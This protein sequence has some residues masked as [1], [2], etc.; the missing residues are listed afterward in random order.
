M[1]SS[2]VRRLPLMCTTEQPESE[3]AIPVVAAEAES[4]AKTR[5][6]RFSRVPSGG[7][8]ALGSR[9]FSNR[10]N[11]VRTGRKRK[12]W[13]KLSSIFADSRLHATSFAS[14]RYTSPDM[15]EHAE[16]KKKSRG[17]R[18]RKDRAKAADKETAVRKKEETE[19]PLRGD[20]I[21]MRPTSVLLSCLA[22]ERPT[23]F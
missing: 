15:R 4:A 22:P 5:R 7:T 13:E 6:R 11:M 10:G 8:Q 9:K 18:S 16:M 3:N 19:P 20:A 1:P 14:R 12:N 17:G 23:L 21:R 2:V